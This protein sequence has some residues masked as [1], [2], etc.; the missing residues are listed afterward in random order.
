MIFTE[1]N[2]HQATSS[3]HIDTYATAQPTTSNSTRPRSH[4]TQAAPDHISVSRASRSSLNQQRREL[5]ENT[6]EQNVSL[7]VDVD[8]NH[9]SGST[10][11][12]DFLGQHL[13]ENG[14]LQSKIYC[15][16]RVGREILW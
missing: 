10:E 1:S 8:I 13:L 16:W 12:E 7:H 6:C 3:Q 5:T 9:I 14:V 4:A 11:M 2:D 15:H